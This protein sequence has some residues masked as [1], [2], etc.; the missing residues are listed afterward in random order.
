MWHS[1]GQRFLAIRSRIPVL[2]VSAVV[3]RLALLAQQ[4]NSSPLTVSAS[5]PNSITK[6]SFYSGRR[7]AS[8]RCSRGHPVGA[9]KLP[10][11]FKCAGPIQ[12]SDP[13]QRIRTS[14]FR[15]TVIPNMSGPVLGTN[16]GRNVWGSAVGVLVS[17]EPFDFGRRH[18]AR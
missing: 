2:C 17:W 15:Q 13:E 1:A 4:P 12:S 8:E 10:A 16:D 5:R 18:A 6:I 9:D 11:K 14:C 3:A 7:G